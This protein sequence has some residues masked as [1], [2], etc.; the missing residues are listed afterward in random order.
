MFIDFSRK[1]YLA[2]RVIKFG[3]TNLHVYNAHT[4][5]GEK[6]ENKKQ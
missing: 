3:K 1:L 6:N 4:N 2:I 5:L